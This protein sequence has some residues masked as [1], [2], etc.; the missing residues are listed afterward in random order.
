M[1]VKHTVLPDG[2]L[3]T[4]AFTVL[5]QL[6]GPKANETEMSIA[7]STKFGEGRNFGVFSSRARELTCHANSVKLLS[8]TRGRK[9][10]F[11]MAQDGTST[12]RCSPERG[13]ELASLPHYTVA[14]IG[15][16]LAANSSLLVGRELASLAHNAVAQDGSSLAR[17]P[18]KLEEEKSCDPSPQIA[19]IGFLFQSFP[20]KS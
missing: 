6:R 19:K 3:P 18:P 9:A 14:Q 11:T 15:I 4:V 7:L 5:V 10:Y 13:K 2:Q 8:I 20:Q 17:Q 1:G 12:T 16:P